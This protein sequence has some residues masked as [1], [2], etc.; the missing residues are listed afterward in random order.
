MIV[1]KY[2]FSLT[3]LMGSAGPDTFVTDLA[4]LLSQSAPEPV[5]GSTGSGAA[6][7]EAVKLHFYTFGGLLATSDWA[8]E[9]S[10]AQS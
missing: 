6:A 10:A 7:R 4:T 9:F 8:R 2:G 1:K 5:E 3:N